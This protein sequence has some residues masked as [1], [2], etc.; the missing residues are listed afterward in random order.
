MSDS[1]P[2]GSPS[3][4]LVSQDVIKAQGI[5]CRPFWDED[6]PL[7]G[8]AYDAY[9]EGH[10]EF[11]LSVRQ[12]TLARLLKA[13]QTLPES[14]QL[15]LKAGYRPLSVQYKVLGITTQKAA[16]EH[17]E[18]SGDRCLDYARNYVSDPS[19][20]MP[21]H[22]TGGAIDIDVLDRI[23]GTPIDFGCPP[24]TDDEIAWL[25]CDLLTPEQAYNRQL[26]LEAMT[27][28][29]FAPLDTEWWHFQYGEELWAKYFH[30]TPIYTIVSEGEP[31]D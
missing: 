7:E 18:W 22:C 9:L 17:P 14:W 24:N 13:R 1:L 25:K 26:L 31:H 5:L 27:G 21:P 30:Q 20:L 12:T 23:S 29:G 4:P 10:P 15:V 2:I 6:D 16:R 11:S 19:L 28:A 3:E 8:V